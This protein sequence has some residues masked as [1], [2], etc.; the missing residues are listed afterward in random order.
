MQAEVQLLR[1]AKKG[2]YNRVRNAMRSC[3]TLNC[4][5]QNGYTALHWAAAEGHLSILQILLSSKRVNVNAKTKS[6]ATALHWAAG[7]GTTEA[8][9]QLLANKA[10]VKVEDDQAETPLFWSCTN[11]HP[12]IALLLLEAKSNPMHADRDG[13]TALEIARSSKSQSSRHAKVFHALVDANK[14]AERSRLAYQVLRQQKE[15]LAAT[16]QSSTQWKRSKLSQSDIG[17]ISSYRG[18]KQDER[19][20]HSDYGRAQTLSIAST[21]RKIKKDRPPT[22]SPSAVAWNKREQQLEVQLHELQQR[23]DLAQKNAVIEQQNNFDEREQKLKSEIHELRLKIDVEQ[24]NS[25][26]IE[27]Q[28][29]SFRQKE[30]KLLAEVA[31]LEIHNN[32]LKTK[33]NGLRE[34]HEQEIETVTVG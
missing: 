2:D 14:R 8:V 10:K 25:K 26:S 34:T 28:V 3:K 1:A 27:D 29:G 12:K 16:V 20:K 15:E 9:K 30:T 32:T 13:M 7:Q 33:I 11:G 19:D 17:S 18:S 31:E 6:G 5:D 23:I 22:R 24:R 4:R 21:N